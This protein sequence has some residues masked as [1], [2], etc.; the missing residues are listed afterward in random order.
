MAVLALA[1]TLTV[2]PAFS[3]P[4][5]S[6][7]ALAERT[8][9]DKA[10]SVAD[11]QARIAALEKFIATNPNS[12]FLEQAM[13]ALVRSHATIG[14]IALKARDPKGAAAAFT[15]ALAAA[16]EKISDRLFSQVI[17][18][19]PVVLASAGYRF[20]GIQ[21]MRSFEKRFEPAPR[22]LIQIGYFYVS[23]ESPRDA[24]RVLERAAE[25]SPDD[26]K[27]WNSLGTAYVISL[28]IDDA[29]NA[30]SKAIAL[31]PKE[32]FA[33]TGLAH[34]R[35][36]TGNVPE[37]IELYKKQ[38][39][40]KPE[41]QGAWGGLAVAYLMNDDEA[42]ANNALAK[43]LSLA[44][45]DFRLYT[46]L[47]FFYV[48][49]GK[50]N[51]AR[52][53]IELAL[54]YEPRFSWGHITL[55]NILLAEKRYREAIEAFNRAQSYGDFPTMH[56]ELGKAYMVADRYDQAIE[57][58]QAAFDITDDG[59]FE[60]SL[61]DVLELRTRRL[62]M[63]LERERQAV[64]FLSDQPTTATQYRLAEALARIGH[65]VELIPEGQPEIASEDSRVSALPAPVTL[66][67]LAMSLEPGYGQLPAPSR[68]RKEEPAPEPPAEP[69]A[70]EPAS[71]EPAQEPPGEDAQ[72]ETRTR[73]RT[74]TRRAETPAPADG[75]VIADEGATPGDA[76]LVFRPRRVA[77]AAETAASE[78]AAAPASETPATESA[79]TDSGATETPAAE[80]AATDTPAGSV[81]ATDIP[82]TEPDSTTTPAESTGAPSETASTPAE[83][84]E[85][86]AESAAS[87]VETATSPATE[88]ASAEPLAPDAGASSTP[89]ETAETPAPSES[90]PASDESASTA[91]ESAATTAEPAG[92]PSRAETEPAEPAPD[93]SAATPETAVTAPSEAPTAGAAPASDVSPEVAAATSDD[94][95]SVKGERP[96]RGEPVA[97]S[98]GARPSTPEAAPP[99]DPA[100]AGTSAADAA[101]AEASAAEAA[102]AEVAPSEPDATGAAAAEPS[103]AAPTAAA[104]ATPAPAASG[105]S[106]SP[107]SADSADS[108]PSA[109][110]AE[111]ATDGA[112]APAETATSP[113]QPRDEGEAGPISPF[114]PREG[115]PTGAP[116]HPAE[117]ATTAPDAP[118]AQVPAPST[119]PDE[120]QTPAPPVVTRPPAPTLDPAVLEK[121]GQAIDAFVGVDDGREP[122]RK[123]WVARKLADKGVLLD[124]AERLANEALDAAATA[125]EV[126]RSVRDLPQL[127]RGGRL[128]VFTA[129]AESTLG[130]VLFKRGRQQDAL[131]HL[132]K[133][134]ETGQA[135]PGFRERVWQFALAKQQE[136]DEKG[137]LVLFIK[138][139]DPAAPTARFQR[140]QIEALYRKVNGSL[141]GL[142]EMLKK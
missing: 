77:A 118:D 100:E 52:E 45:G 14:E 50:V 130:W 38:L 140:G 25:L 111:R 48:S 112:D 42:S 44:P 134:A 97:E 59:Q 81:P 20:D 93:A 49:R 96:R 27:A 28:R 78:P 90:A 36:A 23:I 129:R 84:A 24:V 142:D 125:T 85:A 136:G 5:D 34:M 101:S 74:V 21:L 135:D 123:L 114:A 1:S 65:Y 26:H 76:P 15:R 103:E 55:G 71:A 95:E 115:T 138:A 8:E 124:R 89:A 70:S 62:D 47:A 19:M 69:A 41:D 94:P 141:D 30:F 4:Q 86:P 72:V 29:A 108:A 6:G 56:F 12:V 75:V 53:A 16:P 117:T 40:V 2:P 107:A 99:T 60:T 127:D 31:E 109:E 11:A 39:E 104:E 73:A 64:L 116:A 67:L 137:A 18:Q 35:R 63:L 120:I 131:V 66:A 61:G 80:T 119:A 113:V 91:A 54:K 32:E 17:W 79:A 139:F 57:Q 37:A 87:P 43:A 102:P 122:F 46:Q 98:D 132:A 68:K 92:E 105:E 128:E 121:L 126:D 58:F 88:A 82:T 9:L 110:P 22:R 133:G 33:Y 51:K 106:S 7:S 3:A 13:E 10:L 83:S